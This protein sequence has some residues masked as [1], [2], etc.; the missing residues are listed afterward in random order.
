MSDCK[1]YSNL[2]V[3]W[4]TAEEASVIDDAIGS[5]VYNKCIIN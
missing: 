5:V 2:Q 4:F 3:S 1:N